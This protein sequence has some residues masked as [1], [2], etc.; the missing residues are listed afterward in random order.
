M[1]LLYLTPLTHDQQRTFG[2]APPA[3]LALADR[4]RFGELDALNHVNN[5][6]YMRWFETLRIR[7]T[8]D[9]GISHHVA[10]PGDPRIVIRS[11]QIHYRQEMHMDQDYIAT[12]GC[13]GFR[14]TSF[15]LRQ[16]IWADG[17]LRASFDCV[18]VLLQNDG[19]GDRFALP[20]HL[21]SRFFE[22]DGAAPEV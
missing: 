5:V 3:P 13:I 22:V 6:A 16:Q 10:Q 2:I 15:S 8:Q 20:E 7:Y 12:C 1:P 9:W 14:N 18:M 4:V 17:S 21:K 19:S 11:G